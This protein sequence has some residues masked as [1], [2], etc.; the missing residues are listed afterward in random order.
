[1]KTDDRVARQRLAARALTIAGSDSGGGAGIQA[2][3]KTFAAYRVFGTA[4]VTAITA[5]NTL[6]V[7][8]V[9][10][11]RADLVCAQIDAVVEDIGTDAA[12]TGMLGTADIIEA[13]ADAVRRH[14]IELLV[15]DPVMV[16]TS[17]D[18]LLDPEAVDVLVRALL[19]QAACV[20]PNLA[21]AEALVGFPV[22]D[23]DS[24]AAAGRALLDAGAGAALIKGGHL[25]GDAADLLLVPGGETWLRSE[26]LDTPHTHGTGC[27]L[28]AGLAAGLARGWTLQQAARSAKHFV[29]GAI[30]GA[31]GLGGGHGPLWHGRERPAFGAEDTEVPDD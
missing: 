7:A 11:L 16:A 17:G 4:A 20:T 15:V 13:V 3:L 21:E 6:G 27:T 25:N 2:D 18:P 29:H 8:A 31:P 22:R 23:A 5:Q 28:S 30:R 14:R 26:R 9:S 19:P 1:M 24:M 10:M 12:K